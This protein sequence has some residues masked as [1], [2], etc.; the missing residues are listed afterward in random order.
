MVNP[1]G[2]LA[3]LEEEIGK[4]ARSFGGRSLFHSAK[5]FE[6]ARDALQD[7]RRVD[8]E[9]TFR[10][11]HLFGWIRT[12]LPQAKVHLVEPAPTEQWE[13]P[14]VLKADMAYA[15]LT[16]LSDET[17][18]WS[19]GARAFAL[20]PAEK[21]IC[22]A[23]GA[24]GDPISMPG[25]LPQLRVYLRDGNPWQHQKKRWKELCSEIVQECGLQMNGAYARWL[26]ATDVEK[27]ER[28]SPGDVYPRGDKKP[29]RSW[30]VKPE[31]GAR[32][33]K[34]RANLRA[35][36][37]R[38]LS[39]NRRFVTLPFE[40]E[41]I[42][43]APLVALPLEGRDH[44]PCHGESRCREGRPAPRDQVLRGRTR[45]TPCRGLRRR[46]L[47]ARRG[48]HSRLDPEIGE[49]TPGGPVAVTRPSPEA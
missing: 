9:P 12:V 5:V 20:G 13:R 22:R 29:P 3:V 37:R 27:Q 17:Y 31:A 19:F 21:E 38:E 44:D 49:R 36:S 11:D 15:A 1:P 42:A 47:P 41:A 40:L 25:S 23:L 30:T 26:E 32:I 33:E 46:R 14:D 2:F 24:N 35:L 6:A 45:A 34:A 39:I 4:S 8:R 10:V 48:R 43:S 18:L 7:A 16:G 28:G